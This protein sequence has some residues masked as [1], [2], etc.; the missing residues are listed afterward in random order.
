MET[1][2]RPGHE[3]IAGGGLIY[4]FLPVRLPPLVHFTGENAQTSAADILGTVTNSTGVAVP[5]ATVTLVNKDTR[6][7][8]TFQTEKIRTLS[9]EMTKHNHAQVS[10]QREDL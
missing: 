1:S 7:P 8:R 5:K 2:G 10:S 3:R 4:S 9:V 6:I